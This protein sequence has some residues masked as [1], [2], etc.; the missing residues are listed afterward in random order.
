[1]TYVRRSFGDGP[2]TS[3]DQLDPQGG[4]LVGDVTGVKRV[5]CEDLPRDS[6][7][8]KPGGPCNPGKLD[9]SGLEAAWNYLVDLARGQPQTPVPAP[10]TSSSL[11]PFLLVGGVATGAYYMFRKKKRA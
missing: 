8:W 3:P 2:I 7:P 4:V 11:L 9:T 6:A 10:E 1:M 5:P